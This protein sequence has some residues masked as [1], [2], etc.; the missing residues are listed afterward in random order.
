MRVPLNTQ[1]DRSSSKVPRWLKWIVHHFGSGVVT[2]AVSVP[3]AMN[4]SSSDD[5]R[6]VVIAETDRNTIHAVMPRVTAISTTDQNVTI[7]SPMKPIA[8]T[9]YSAYT[10]TKASAVW[11]MT[12]EMVL[13]MNFHDGSVCRHSCPGRLRA[14]Q[15]SVVDAAAATTAAPHRRPHRRRSRLGRRAADP[16]RTAPTRSP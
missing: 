16:A 8:S 2:M 11:T 1:L 9:R 5:M 6:C 10:A 3:M 4:A 15:Y 14:R 12:T 13:T 7:G